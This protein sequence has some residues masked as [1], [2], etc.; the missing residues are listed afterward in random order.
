[1]SQKSILYIINHID[2]FWS[3]RLPL[4][5]YARDKGYK[6]YV[7]AYG[8]SQDSDL[9]KNGFYPVELPSPHSGNALFAMIKII[10]R[11]RTILTEIGPDI[12]HAITLKYVFIT[13]LAALGYKQTKPVFT[14][15][16]LGYLFSSEGLKPKLLRFL[17]SPFLKLAFSHP[18]MSAIFQNPDDME[19]LT[20]R[21]FVNKNNAFLIKGSGVDTDKFSYAPPPEQQTPVVLMPT[22]LV[23][24]KGVNIFAD[25]AGILKKQGVEARFLIAGGLDNVN[26]LAYSEKEM[27]KIINQG[28]VEWL[29]KVKDMPTLYHS[30]C[31]IA[32]PSHYREGIPKV[33]LEAAACGKPIVT[34]DHPGCR[35]VVRHGENGYLVPVKDPESTAN[36]VRKL[37]ENQEVQEKFGKKSRERAEKEFDVNVI[38]DKTLAVYE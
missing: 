23:K 38:V 10:R 32:Y 36:A 20:K 29:G 2:W 30:A 15:A 1:M 7:A 16:G 8:A 28:N 37:L 14:I 9:T 34:T 17:I 11:I 22:R 4:A 12:T 25:A 33:L 19:I 21:G 26:P 6:V 31:I 27:N 13:G 24:D 35:E 18:E 5:R 3:H